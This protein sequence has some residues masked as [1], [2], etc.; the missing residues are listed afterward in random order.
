MNLIEKLKTLLNSCEK[1][2]LKSKTIWVNALTLAAGLLAT[3]QGVASPEWV[4]SALAGVNIILRFLTTGAITP[5]GEV[6]EAVETVVTSVTNVVNTE[7]EKL[8]VK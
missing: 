1:S 7:K 6:V 2:P 5:T 3:V 4:I 8:N